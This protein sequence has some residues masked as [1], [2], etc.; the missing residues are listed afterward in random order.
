MYR[1]TDLDPD[2][3]D[4]YVFVFLGLPDPHSDPLVRDTDPQIRIRIRTKM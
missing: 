1:C 2:P 3:W 4:L